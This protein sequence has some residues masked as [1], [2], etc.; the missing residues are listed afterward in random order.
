[1]S[2]RET[3][4]GVSIEIRR[5]HRRG[6]LADED[7]PLDL[8][9]AVAPA[10]KRRHTSGSLVQGSI[11][12]DVGES[13]WGGAAA[14]LKLGGRSKSAV[15]VIQKNDNRAWVRGTAATV[16]G[17]YATRRIAPVRRAL[18]RGASR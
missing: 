4:T 13:Q 2:P 10:E 5:H 7:F 8:E 15:A 17:D 12:I 6:A 18:M 3:T 14:R 16:G 1:M 11:A 9:C